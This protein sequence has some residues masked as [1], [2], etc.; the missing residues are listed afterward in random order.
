MDESRLASVPL[1]ASLS[2]EQRARL[3]RVTDEV[4]IPAGEKLV[5]E[6]DFAY[7][8]FIIE[9]GSAEVT[10]G[11]R[12][13]AELGPGDFFG[14]MGV[15]RNAPRNADVVTTSDT[16]AIVMTWYEFRQIAREMPTVASRIEAAIED[17]SKV[18]AG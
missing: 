11:G 18:L 3:A 6:G 9:D 8:I 14:E 16:K 2:D 17:R 15:M 1:F 10:Q 4:E 12:R 13:V 7:E 5:N